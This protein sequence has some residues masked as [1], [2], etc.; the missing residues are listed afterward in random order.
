VFHDNGI[1]ARPIWTPMHLLP[2]YRNCPRSRLSITED[3]YARCI[4]LPS[5]PSLTARKM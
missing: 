2:M 5:S 4:N 3:I 1:Q